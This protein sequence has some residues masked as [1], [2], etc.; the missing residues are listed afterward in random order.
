MVCCSGRV[1]RAR[2]GTAKICLQKPVFSVRLLIIDCSEAKTRDFTGG[3]GSIWSWD[4]TIHSTD[5]KYI[6]EDIVKNKARTWSIRK[7]N[8]ISSNG[9]G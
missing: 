3:D 4:S 6:H 2:V 7:Q 9:S 1:N 8:T 5:K